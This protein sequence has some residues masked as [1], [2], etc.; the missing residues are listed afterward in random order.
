MGEFSAAVIGKANAQSRNTDTHKQE[1]SKTRQGCHENQA[2]QPNAH[3]ISF[4]Y[5]R[6]IRFLLASAAALVLALD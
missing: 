1:A 2:A 5:F 4:S 6:F 3:R